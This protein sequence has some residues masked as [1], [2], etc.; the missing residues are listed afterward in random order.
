[1]M[2]PFFQSTVTDAAKNHKAGWRHAC[3]HALDALVRHT[4]LSPNEMQSV[5][6]PLARREQ[7]HPGAAIAA[8]VRARARRIS[9][10]RVHGSTTA[11]GGHVDDEA[12]L[13]GLPMGGGPAEAGCDQPAL[14]FQTV[15]CGGQLVTAHVRKLGCKAAPSLHGCWQRAWASSYGRAVVHGA[16]LLLTGGQPRHPGSS[17]AA[18]RLPTAR[19]HRPCGATP[20]TSGRKPAS[21]KPKPRAHEGILH[22]RGERGEDDAHK[23]PAAHAAT[24][25][26]AAESPPSARLHHLRG[27]TNAHTRLGFG[28]LTQGR[29]KIGS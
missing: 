5:A 24:D 8:V 17:N 18:C 25:S 10:I 23:P 28:K 26:S 15:D 13:G 2:T 22:P 7:L 1:M 14:A 4:D 21:S 29:S 3:L 27:E 20:H 12:T 6:V 16:K 19:H 11:A 9:T